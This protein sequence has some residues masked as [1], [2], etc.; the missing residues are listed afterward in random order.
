MA[1]GKA[2]TRGTSGYSKKDEE[3]AKK[4]AGLERTANKDNPNFPAEEKKNRVKNA[5]A[6]YLRNEKTSKGREVNVKNMDFMTKEVE[7]V[8]KHKWK[9]TM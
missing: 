4:Y 8:N 7:D 9:G 6:N 5:E 2:Y 3:D 1:G